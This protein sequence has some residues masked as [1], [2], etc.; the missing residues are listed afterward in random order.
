VE[1]EKLLVEI[2]KIKLLFFVTFIGGV[3]GLFIKS[4]LIL[5]QIV[6]AFLTLIGIIG[7]IKNLKELGNLYS[8]IKDKK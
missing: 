1:R 8:F 5:N 7:V 3:F 2:I 4:N 6:F